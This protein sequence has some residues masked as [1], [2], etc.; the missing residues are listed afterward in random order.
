MTPTTSLP[1][2]PT[3]QPI[4]AKNSAS[5]TDDSSSCRP[6]RRSP[7]TKSNYLGPYESRSASPT[8]SHK[9]SLKHSRA[10]TPTSPMFVKLF[11]AKLNDYNHPKDA[12]DCQS[13]GSSVQDESRPSSPS[14][15]HLSPHISPCS[16][17]A[18][19]EFRCKT[20]PSLINLKSPAASRKNSRVVSPS[21]YNLSP[22]SSMSPR[23][24]ISSSN[25]SPDYNTTTSNDSPEYQVNPSPNLSSNGSIFSFNTPEPSTT[26]TPVMTPVLTPRSPLSRSMAS[27]RS[28]RPIS[29]L[30]TNT[31]TEPEKKEYE[32]VKLWKT[33]SYQHQRKCRYF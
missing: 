10:T 21:P 12:A 2:D 32:H 31:T 14:C 18:I 23:S 17:P 20:S 19:R 24:L 4:S 22:A 26:T 3:F 13:R 7:S 8:F 1:P 27:M 15:H 11:T 30:V 29:P 28:L 33:N 9:S 5:S 16:S 25:I 6:Q